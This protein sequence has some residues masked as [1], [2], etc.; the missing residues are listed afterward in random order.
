MQRY[1]AKDAAKDKA[2]AAV[3]EKFPEDAAKLKA[4]GDVLGDMTKKIVRERIV[5]EGTRIDGR[6]TKT[7]YNF[8]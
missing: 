8:V 5:K 2:K 1:A 4:V 6:D 3:A 7:S